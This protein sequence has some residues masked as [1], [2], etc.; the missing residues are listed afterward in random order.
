MKKQFF[1]SAVTAL[2]AQLSYGQGPTADYADD[3]FRFSDF[4][5]NGTARFRGIGG[6][7]AAL[8]GDASNI[9]GNPAGLGFYNRSELSISPAFTSS[10]NQT[11]FLGQQLNGS[12]GK[13]SVG[14]LGLVIAGSTN[15]SRRWKRSAFGVTY[16]QSTNFYDYSDARGQNNN[17]NSSLLQTYINGA[18]SA[19][20]SEA[21]LSDGFRPGERQADFTE[22]AAYGLYLINPTDLGQ[23]GSGPP[24]TRYDANT[25]KDQ[26]A[27]RTQSGT[28]SQW[29]LA[30]AGNL[31][32]KFYIGG[33]LALT[34]LRYAYESVFIETPIN[35]A[36]FNNYGQTTRVDVTG[37]GINLTLGMIYKLM[38]ELQ[39]GATIVSPTWSSANEVFG[40]TLNAS[41]RTPNPDGIVLQTNYVDVVTPYDNF[42]YSLQTPLRASA[43]A[44]FFMG[45][46][47]FLTATAEYVGY[48]TMR[49]RT[50]TFSNQ[51]DN[52]DFKNDVKSIIQDSYDNVINLRG[53]AEIR[54]GLFRIRAGVG[55]LPSA[56]K[57][58]LDR[59]AR[60]DRT[61]LLFSGGIGVRNDRF[62]ADLSGTYLTYKSG[63]SPFQLPSDADTPTVAVSNRNT[64]VMLSLGVFF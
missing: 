22:A 9:F 4:S 23:N 27:T 33:S 38:P 59:V 21:E 19:R 3:A 54:A 25:R 31:D 61:K 62:F 39:V 60:A 42:E 18:N 17:A 36:Y 57:L 51:Q 41:V 64:N 53:G 2:A 43:G 58:N 55:Y 48:Q 14:E 56:Y 37:N 45:K 5:Q 32:N 20:Y 26:R 49:V 44:T 30:Y 46:F 28:H 29:T 7:H 35:G 40:R 6:N 13:V 15:G 1:L 47:G 24:Y 8:G 63:F 34:R 11:T 10:N 50:S 16:S 12:N 52:T